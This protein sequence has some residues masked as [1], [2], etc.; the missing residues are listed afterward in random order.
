MMAMSGT[1][2]NVDSVRHIVCGLREDSVADEYF[3]RVKAIA[4][5]NNP[6]IAA[7]MEKL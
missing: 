4:A 5:A 2:K 3:A 6:D 1:V 7:E